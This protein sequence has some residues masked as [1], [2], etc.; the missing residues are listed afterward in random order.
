MSHPQTIC[1]T[2]ASGQ[3]G[4]AV[5]ACRPDVWPLS[6]RLESD[7]DG[8]ICALDEKKPDALVHAAAYTAVDRAEVEQEVSN[9]VNHLSVRTLSQWCHINKTPIV[10]YST[11]YVFDGRKPAPYLEDDFCNPLNQYGLSKHRGEL[12]FVEEDPPGCIF[13]TSWVLGQGKNFVQKILQLGLEKS[14]LHVIDDQIGRPTSASLLALATLEYLDRDLGHQ[15]L[16][17]LFHL[18]DSGEPVSW[19]GLAVYAVNRAKDWSYPGLTSEQIFPVSAEAFGQ[20]VRRPQNSLL[21]C[22]RFD[23]VFSVPRPNW[24]DTVDTL[25]EEHAAHAW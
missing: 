25:V 4:R 1:I 22:E 9:R 19:Y 7:T 23:R 11:D 3:V 20:D 5:I 15:A 13:R 16:P 14:T 17:K 24:R 12:A 10:H 2:G 21:D 8:L 6:N 18:T